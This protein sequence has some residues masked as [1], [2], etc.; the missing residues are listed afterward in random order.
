MRAFPTIFALLI[1][2]AVLVVPAA[3]AAEPTLPRFVDITSDAGIGFIHSIGDDE[4]S[5]IVES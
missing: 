1:L 5:N 3:A 4:L 2:A